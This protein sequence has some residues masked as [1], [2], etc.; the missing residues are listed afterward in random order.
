[1]ANTRPYS[2]EE[3]KGLRRADLQKL[4]KTHNLKGAN[5][6]NATLIDTLVEYFVSPGY[7]EAF[8]RQTAQSSQ[9]PIKGTAGKGERSIKP[10]PGKPDAVKRATGARQVGETTRYGTKTVS[11]EPSRTAT[12]MV[13]KRSDKSGSEA[14]LTLAAA[15]RDIAVQPPMTSQSP[16][17]PSLA[18]LQAL[19][20]SNNTKW[21]ARLEG[22][23]RRLTDEVDRLRREIQEVRLTF[24]LQKAESAPQA[25]HEDLMLDR[26]EDKA[27]STGPIRPT[28]SCHHRSTLL[29]FSSLGKRRL[30][31]ERRVDATDVNCK[32]VRFNSG[33]PTKAPLAT[34]GHGQLRTPSPRKAPSSFPPDFFARSEPIVSAVSLLDVVPRTPPPSRQ[35]VVSD[36]SQ[37]PRLPTEW[38]QTGDASK[39]I[40]L[41]DQDGPEFST[42]PEPPT[43]NVS[44]SREGSM[45]GARPAFGRAPS[46]LSRSTPD[47]DEEEKGPGRD[48]E[49]I[50]PRITMDLE[51]IEE[52]EETLPSRM[53]ASS[54]TQL[55]FPA[56]KP[57]SSLGLSI[58]ILGS[59]SPKPGRR[60]ISQPNQSTT[61]SLPFQHSLASPA[62]IGRT[63]HVDSERPSPST[64][65][66]TH[67]P[68][69]SQLTLAPHKQSQNRDTPF[70][71]SSRYASSLPGTIIPTEEA[72]RVQSASADYMRIAMYGLEGA[73][74][75]SIDIPSTSTLPD[76]I[77]E[78]PMAEGSNGSNRGG[79]EAERHKWRKVD[80]VVTP[81]QRT[82]LG[83]ER[84][85]DTRFGDIPVGMWAQPKID[86]GT[87]GTPF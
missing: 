72:P 4:Y 18:D 17:E 77:E 43:R 69:R 16:R 64:S 21:E 59:A 58:G 67:S 56:K 8:P 62:L 14:V 37:T 11:A 68:L 28:H 1:M 38:R 87:P 35:G 20:Q 49:S 71:N 81:G 13:R 51:R 3:L 42:T 23:E 83:T 30:S 5:G 48:G 19:L 34:D 52:D 86:F 74:L 27:P 15:D 31:L 9:G 2:R 50:L 55:R 36:N 29:P 60:A 10:L 47:C 78:G 26:I 63:L 41:H 45:V 22:V 75:D 65:A 40:S 25:R 54:T 39:A 73:S 53:V 46:N 7:L 85:N 70:H 12:G 82:L 57:P 84:Y 32:R 80:E 44:P 6:N 79:R 24:E 61:S 76:L 33:E 66:Q